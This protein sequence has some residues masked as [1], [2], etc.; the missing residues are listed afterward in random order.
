MS[1]GPDGIPGILLKK[2]I[3]S[4]SGPLTDFWNLSMRIGRI[5]KRLK[6][7][8]VIP[9][10][11]PGSSKNLPASWRPISET[12]QLMKTQ[13]RSVKRFLQSHLEINQLLNNF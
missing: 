6:L 4:L 12:S 2:F 5:L 10:H 1:S 9:Q 8:F 3:D 11:K 13:E 7:A